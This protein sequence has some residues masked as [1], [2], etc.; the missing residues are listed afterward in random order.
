M[1]R[2]EKLLEAI[3]Q[4]DA[5]LIL[6]AQNA[7]KTAQ[8]PIVSI[9][10]KKKSAVGKQKKQRNQKAAV[11]RFQGALAACAVLA[12]CFGVYG[13]LAYNGLLISPF[14]KK[15]D[16]AEYTRITTES[17]MDMADMAAAPA[18]KAAESPAASNQMPEAKTAKETGNEAV[19]P[20]EAEEAA[21]EEAAAEEAAEEAVDTSSSEAKSSAQEN[22]KSE[23]AAEEPAEN[24]SAAGKAGSGEIQTQETETESGAAAGGLEESIGQ[25]A[26]TGEIE[27]ALLQEP[28]VLSLRGNDGVSVAAEGT[29]N[30]EISGNETTPVQELSAVKLE[31]KLLKT[32][33]TEVT[34]GYSNLYTDAAVIYGSMYELEQQTARGWIKV[35]VLDGIVW[36][37][38]L[39]ELEPGKTAKET[40]RLT[41]MFGELPTGHYRLVKNCIADH[42]DQTQEEIVIYTEFDIIK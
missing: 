18:E 24:E 15:S 38:I 34:L 3:G 13:M 17:A 11:L 5:E 16:S 42:A 22:I 19:I 21:A 26:V 37:D 6:E 33:G 29:E 35:P 20:E 9:H 23:S 7:G 31:A 40:I 4:I 14:S 41:T 10:D 30:E 32:E 12:I 25:E 28:M 8:A 27:V 36:V 1:N 39:Y 2:N